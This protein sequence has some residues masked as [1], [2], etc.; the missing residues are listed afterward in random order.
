VKNRASAKRSR[1]HQNVI[2]CLPFDRPAEKVNPRANAIVTLQDR[3]AARG[4]LMGPL[5]GF[6]LAVEDLMPA[7]RLIRGRIR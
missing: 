6:P 2:N 4:E 7:S 1:C 3:A 5:H